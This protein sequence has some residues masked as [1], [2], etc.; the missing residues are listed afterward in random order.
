MPPLIASVLREGISQDK[1]RRV[2]TEH[3]TWA[4][5]STP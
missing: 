3:L 4:L 2:D 5:Q 1:L